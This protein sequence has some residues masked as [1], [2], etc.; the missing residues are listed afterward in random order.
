MTQDQLQEVG[1]RLIWSEF[2]FRA[3][4][5]NVFLSVLLVF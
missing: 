5:I 3:E 1:E 2:V 4:T